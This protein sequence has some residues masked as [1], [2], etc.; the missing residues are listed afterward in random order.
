MPNKR[1]Q[2][3]MV[4]AR[5]GVDYLAEQ[6]GVDP[7]TVQRWIQGRTPHPRHR[8]NVA[9]T[10]GADQEYLWPD[11]QP[12]AGNRIAEGVTAYTHRENMAV[13]QWWELF[14]GGRRR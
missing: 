4:T 2:R 6:T 7:K 10:L 5:V 9:L 1:L 11:Q 14:K 8:L 13:D 3:A 12:A